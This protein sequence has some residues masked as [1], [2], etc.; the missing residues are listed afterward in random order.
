MALGFLLA[1]CSGKDKGEGDIALVV[2][3]TEVTLLQ[4]QKDISA[5][6]YVADLVPSLSSEKGKKILEQVIDDYLVLEYARE[7]GIEVTQAELNYHVRRYLTD[8]K[9][10]ALKE[11]L[12]RESLDLAQWKEQLRKRLTIKKVAEHVTHSVSP[13]S[14]DELK[15]YFEMHEKDFNSPPMVRFRQIVCRDRARAVEALKKLKGGQDFGEIARQY[16]FAP[17]ADKGGE[18]GWISKGT[19]DPSMEDTLFSLKVGQISPVVKTPY[20]YHIFQV[21]EKRE[22][23]RGDLLKVVNKIEAEL[24]ARKKAEVYSRWLE[25]LRKKYKVKINHQLLAKVEGAK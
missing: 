13:P 1:A 17:E 14:K 12:L 4:L 19:L 10:E 7:H 15:Q 18:V 22:G 6:G 20:G 21:L 8:Y 24:L 25:E 23:A 16:S 2:G 5:F 3:S 9:E 11:T